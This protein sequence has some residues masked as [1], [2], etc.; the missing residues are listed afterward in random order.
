M[1]N[2]DLAKENEQRKKEQTIRDDPKWVRGPQARELLFGDWRLPSVSGYLFHR[3][4]KLTTF[5]Q[6]ESDIQGKDTTFRVLDD[7]HVEIVPPSMHPNLRTSPQKYEFLVN[8]DELVLLDD[9]PH[10]IFPVRGPYYRVP[11]QPGKPGYEKVIAP[12]LAE[13]KSSDRGKA[14]TAFRE[15]Q[16]L[17][18][19][20]APGL[21]VLLELA[22]GPDA[23]VADKAIF[24]IGML[25]DAATPA[26]P[27]LIELLRDANEKK[28][29]AAVY[30]LGYIGPPAK[31]ALPTLRAL[32]AKNPEWRTRD[33]LT[34]AVERIEGKKKP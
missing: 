1:G 24:V 5:Q 31:D 25:G 33:S 14:S 17:G 30:A 6:Y 27:A 34:N 11:A 7:S 10:P 15:Y 21:P 13:V 9:S 26:I 18:K 8:Q 32:L 3:D 29:G 23:D 20:G 16:R 12:L 22:R 28:V 2:T 19:S 4:G